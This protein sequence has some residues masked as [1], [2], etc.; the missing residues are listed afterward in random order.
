MGHLRRDC[1]S[2]AQSGPGLSTGRYTQWSCD[3]HYCRMPL[4]NSAILIRPHF[5]ECFSGTA[6]L[7][8]SGTS[9]QCKSLIT[10]LTFSIH[11]RR[12]YPRRCGVG[13]STRTTVLC[14][15]RRQKSFVFQ[16]VAGGYTQ[17]PLTGVGHL[18]ALAWCSIG[19][20]LPYHSDP[21]GRTILKE[22]DANERRERSRISQQ[23]FIS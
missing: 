21:V 14:P 6:L 10:Q 9:H 18:G 19:R 4:T 16:E 23:I 13:S 22:V 5:E 17:C 2:L 7:S 15:L 11:E 20:S 8:H 3:R 1:R 12:Q